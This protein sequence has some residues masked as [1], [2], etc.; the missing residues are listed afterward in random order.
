M[1]NIKFHGKVACFNANRF[2]SFSRVLLHASRMYPDC[3][4]GVY[5][6][7]TMLYYVFANRTDAEL[8]EKL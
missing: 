6:S 8:F 7:T 1:T 4:F 5:D 2:R 3:P